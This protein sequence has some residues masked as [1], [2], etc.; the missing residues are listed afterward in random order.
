LSSLF[1]PQA[2]FVDDLKNGKVAPYMKS[3]P[4]PKNQEGP[5]KSIVSNNYD[6]EIHKVKKDAVLFIHAPWC[7]HCKDFEPVYKKIAKK[8]MKSN[9]NIVF[10][11]MDGTANDIPYMYPPLKGYPAIFFLSAYEKYDPIQY[12]GDRTF[13]SV[14]DWINRHS[15]IFLTEEE[16]TGQAAEE[17]EEIES[18]TSENFEEDINKEKEAEEETKTEEVVEEAE[19]KKDEL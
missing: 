3:Q 7:G 15:S 13:K 9:E 19:K 1:H 14:K 8:M 16:R 5:V 12:Q 6:A 11:K 2:Q 18:F 4:V 10:G 17:E